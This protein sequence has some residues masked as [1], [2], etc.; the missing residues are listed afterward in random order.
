MQRSHDFML[1]LDII[2]SKGKSGLLL[3]EILHFIVNIFISDIKIKVSTTKQ[4]TQEVGPIRCG[5]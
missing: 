4:P 5:S 2:S 3:Y 1:N